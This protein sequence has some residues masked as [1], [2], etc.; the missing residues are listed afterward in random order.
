MDTQYLLPFPSLP[1]HIMVSVVVVAYVLQIPWWLAGYFFTRQDFWYQ[2]SLAPGWKAKLAPVFPAA[3]T[4]LSLYVQFIM[5]CSVYAREAVR[6][7][8]S[9]PASVRCSHQPVSVQ[10]ICL[11]WWWTMADQLLSVYNTLD[12]SSSFLTR[13]SAGKKIRQQHTRFTLGSQVPTLILHSLLLFRPTS[14]LAT[15]SISS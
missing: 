7:D 2:P 3:S 1:W 5:S 8:V 15:A 14:T 10:A 6:C 9:W 13:P 12:S 4:L 11:R